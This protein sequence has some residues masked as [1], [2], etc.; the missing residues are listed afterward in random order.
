MWLLL[1]CT[2]G[3]ELVEG[4]E[5][6]TGGVAVDSG[7][8]EEVNAFASQSWSGFLG[9]SFTDAQG[10][11]CEG[12][13]DLATDEDGS[14][15]GE[16]ACPDPAGNPVVWTFEGAVDTA[17]D[18]TGTVSTQPPGSDQA[19]SFEIGGEADGDDLTI[20]WSGALETPEGEAA[21]DGLFSSAIPTD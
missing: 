4:G 11:A 3:F 16:G 8:G 10:P 12:E 13:G 2:N 21:F 1:A 20:E 5:G 19:L 9:F 15:T 7:D 6:S 18:V 17:G 14:L